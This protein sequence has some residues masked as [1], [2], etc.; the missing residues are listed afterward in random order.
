MGPKV[1]TGSAFAMSGVVWLTGIALYN[2]QS[3]EN[4]VVSVLGGYVA[5]GSL[6]RGLRSDRLVSTVTGLW[7]VAVAL[8][9]LPV[10]GAT[11]TPLGVLLGVVLGLIYGTV[12]F[13]AWVTFGLIGLRLL[14][15]L[16]DPAVAAYRE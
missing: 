1:A 10:V 7:V 3:P 4:L 6:V 8:V 5:L 13:V 9:A 12:A 2:G 15:H 11:A 14:G 16:P